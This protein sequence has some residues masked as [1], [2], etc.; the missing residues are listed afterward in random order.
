MS[1]YLDYTPNLTYQPVHSTVNLATSSI[2]DVATV[3]IPS[4]YWNTWQLPYTSYSDATVSVSALPYI[5]AVEIL[6][7][8]TG[9]KPFEPLFVLFDDQ[10][11]TANTKSLSQ[12]EHAA[13]STGATALGTGLKADGTGNVYGRLYLPANRFTVGI[14]KIMLSNTV[15]PD[16]ASSY[17]DSVFTASGTLNINQTT[18]IHGVNKGNNYVNTSQTITVV[19]GETQTSGWQGVA[20]SDGSSTHNDAS[21]DKASSDQFKA[22]KLAQAAAFPDKVDITV[23]PVNTVTKPLPL[24]MVQKVSNPVIQDLLGRGGQIVSLNRTST[25]ETF[26]VNNR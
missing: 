7:S 23:F 4:G 1:S 26:V 14:K 9:M 17:S 20:L 16:N 5:N 22:N 24:S 19:L 10:N 6:I 13:N 25:L 12:A 2:K 15:N 8:A 3:V 11:V 21:W 18:E